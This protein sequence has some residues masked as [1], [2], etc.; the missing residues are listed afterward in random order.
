M[1]PRT[2]AASAATPRRLLAVCN[3]LGLLAGE[4]YPT[5]AGKGY[6]LSPYLG[7]LKAFRDE[8][9]VFSGV[10]HPN[11]NG[12]HSANVPFLTA[13]PHPGAGSFRNTISLDQYAAERIGSATRFP[14]LT[15]AV[16]SRNRSL[17]YNG[18][19]V[20]VPPE[21][22]RA[23]GYRQLFF[24]GTPEQVEAQVRKLDT[25]ESVLDAVLDQTKRL[26]AKAGPRDRARLDQYF[27]SVP[28]SV[29]S[30]TT[31]C[32]IHTCRCLTDWGSRRIGSRRPPAR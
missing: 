17:S 9:T 21:D 12:Q 6:T 4:F 26:Q 18:S 24:Q 27:T 5:H 11:V 15:L 23:E 14:S 16:N 29:W 25:G 32:R 7:H 13:A 20:R 10:S 28:R 2:K 31:H 19:G 1:T 30:R 22:S 3:N 8:F